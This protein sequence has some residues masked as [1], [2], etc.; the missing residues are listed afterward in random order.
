MGQDREER[1]VGFDDCCRLA[2]H[3]RA[4]AAGDGI[5]MADN[6]AQR[7]DV[8]AAFLGEALRLGGRGPGDEAHHVA[9]QLHLRAS[10]HRSGMDH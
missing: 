6:L 1:V 4:G 10:A 5:T 2:Q 8:E 9:G 3:D 7:L